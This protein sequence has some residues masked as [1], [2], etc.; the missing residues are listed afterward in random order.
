M[1]SFVHAFFITCAI[2]LGDDDAGTSRKPQ[3]KTDQSINN[4]RYVA[5]RGQSFLSDEVTH[6]D[7]VHR[8]VQNLKYVADQKW[9]RESHQVL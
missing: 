6:N 5:Y 9:N 4:R 7:A 3:E 8:I 2:I 1:Y